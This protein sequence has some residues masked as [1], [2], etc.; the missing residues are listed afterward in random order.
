MSEENDGKNFFSDGLNFECTRCSNCCRHDPGYV[1]LTKKDLSRLM[2]ATD[3]NES[4]F[5][6]TYC[7]NVEIGFIERISLTEKSNYDCI[8]WGENGCSVYKHRPLQCRSYPFWSSHLLSPDTW[9]SEGKNCPGIN[10][11]RLYSEKEI[12]KW[13]RSREKEPLLP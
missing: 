2:Q 6:E 1:F 7:R 5:L 9:D 12:E 3:L 10:H 4:K 8:F 13:I 11:G